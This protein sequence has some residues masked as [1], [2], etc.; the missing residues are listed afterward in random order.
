MEIRKIEKKVPKIALLVDAWFP[1]Y[2]GGQVHVAELARILTSEHRYEVDILTRPIKGKGSAYEKDLASIPGLKVKYFGMKS[3]FGNPFMRIFYLVAV[4]FYLLFVG[5]RYAAVHAHAASCTIP[6]K[7]AYWWNRVPTLVTVHGSTLFKRGFSVKKFLEKVLYCETK[8]TQVVSVS[9]NFLKAANVNQH[10]A[11]IPNGID[12]QRFENVEAEKN[13]ETF[14]V[15]FV[16]R[17]DKIKG[18]DVLLRSFKKLLDSDTFLETPKHILLHIV[19]TGAE[20]KRLKSLAEKLGVTNKVRFHGKVT[21][22][23]LVKMYKSSDLFVLPSRSEGFPLSLLEASA[24]KLPILATDVGDNRKLVLEKVNGHLVSPDDVDELAYY[25]EQFI[26]NP[27]LKQMGEHGYELVASTF[28]WQHVAEKMARVYERVIQME[29]PDPGKM[30]HRFFSILKDK[31]MPWRLPELFFEIRRGDA[32]YTGK[33]PLKFCL[34][35]DVEQSYGSAD[36][37]HEGEHV[38]SFME[39]YMDMCGSLE[40]PSTLF[41]QGDLLETYSDYFHMAQKQGHELGIHGLHHELW[42]TPKWF[43]K[44]P[45]Q[46]IPERKKNL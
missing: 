25:L 3:S 10:V 27:H 35:V 34:T 9:E 43:L 44:D 24:A 13:E 15:L 39:R 31:R 11:V 4:F 30:Y 17:L 37:P 42:G 1:L 33:S 40:I 29:T 2:G 22:D 38:A 46:P 19:G 20:E 6:M 7:A 36:Y 41:V 32:K 28:T 8:Y 16:G 14:D 23:A 5:R 18:L 45:W 12:L 21:G 26:Q